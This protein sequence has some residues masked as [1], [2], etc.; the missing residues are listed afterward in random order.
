MTQETRPLTRPF[1]GIAI[2][3]PGAYELDPPHTFITFTVQHMVVG[4]VRG[5]F[6]SRSG[7]IIVAE[8]PTQ[9]S[10]D[11]SVNTQSIDTQ[12]EMSDEDLRSDHFLNVKAFPVMSYRATSVTPD[13]GTLDGELKVR[14]V[15]RRVPLSGTFPWSDYR[16]TRQHTGRL[17]RHRCHQQERVWLDKGARAG[18]PAGFFWVRI[19]SSTSAPKQ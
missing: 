5:R 4:R 19:S 15:T 1:S 8:D 9:S 2:P 16:S 18:N 17:S 12:N 10:L 6:N 7:T 11:V 13:L 3:A 14:D